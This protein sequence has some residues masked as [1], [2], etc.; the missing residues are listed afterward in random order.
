[1]KL[2]KKYQSLIKQ[3]NWAFGV[4]SLGEIFVQKLSKNP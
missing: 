4:G 3:T 2:K 1:M